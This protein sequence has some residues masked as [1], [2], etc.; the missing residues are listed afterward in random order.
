MISAVI[1]P[2][3]G[4]LFLT[5]IVIAAEYIAPSKRY[6]FTA[7]TPGALFGATGFAV[8]LFAITLLQHLWLRLGVRPIVTVPVIGVAG[9]A[10][11]LVLMVLF[12]DFLAYWSHR[13]QHRF[14]WPIHALHHAPTELHVANGY[15]HYLERIADWVLI[16]IPLS[17]VAFDFP[18]TPF[19]LVFTLGLLERYIHSASTIHLGPLATVLVDNR[20]HRIHHSIEKRHFDRNFGIVFSFWDRLFGTAWEPRPE[21]W[22]E[23]GVIGTPPPRSLVDYLIFPLNSRRV[24]AASDAPT[25]QADR[26]VLTN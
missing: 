20:F 6:T 25:P 21:E 4:L 13:F 15:A 3:G 22:P 12:Y 11:S 23:T 24:D 8:A 1:A 16:S 7:R 26:G 2:V 9:S 19:L 10:L 17:L 18:A 5:A 14:L